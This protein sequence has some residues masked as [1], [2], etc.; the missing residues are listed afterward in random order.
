MA[1]GTATLVQRDPMATLLVTGSVTL[2]GAVEQTK[3]LV[4][5]AGYTSGRL[6]ATSAAPTAARKVTFAVRDTTSDATLATREET[7][8]QDGFLV[9]AV[10][11]QT[12]AD[13]GGAPFPMGNLTLGAISDGAD[14]AV[15]TYEL[16]LVAAGSYATDVDGSQ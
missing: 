3:A 5:P 7:A 10:P 16:E 11:S 6:T 9:I 4:I 8:A 1:F 13:H 15:W 12:A 2:A 14:V